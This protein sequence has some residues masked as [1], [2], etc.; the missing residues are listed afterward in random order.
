MLVG[1]HDGHFHCDDVMCYAILKLLYKDIKLIR[2]RDEEELEKCDI[3]FDI[4]EKHDPLNQVFDHHFVDSPIR[5]NGV[6]YASAG[7]IWEHFGI[8]LLAK[9]LPNR[10]L[11]ELNE[12]HN[13]IDRDIMQSID[14]HDT[15]YS[16]AH[17]CKHYTL[18]QVVSSFLPSWYD[19]DLMDEEFIKASDVC[20]QIL[21]NNLNYLNSLYEAER[22]MLEKYEESSDSKVLILDHFVPFQSCIQKHNLDVDAIIYKVKKG[23]WLIQAVSQKSGRKLFPKHWAG[24]K[25]AEL[26]EAAGIKGAIFCHPARFAAGHT[27]K[28]GA[29]EMF[30]MLG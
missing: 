1:T 24:K 29:I 27:T 17:Y 5:S 7:L 26:D 3:L 23:E 25:G 13:K 4:G 10:S 16:P 9:R 8:D 19:F 28:E 30:K 2:T 14:A 15:Y 11:K 18:P 21:E 6:P 12:I 22:V 20:A